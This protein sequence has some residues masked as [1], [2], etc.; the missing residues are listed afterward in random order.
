MKR[1]VKRWLTAVLRLAHGSAPK[2]HRIPFGVLRGR[3]IYMSP[4]MSLRMFFGKAE[5]GISQRLAKLLARDA[6]V[7][8][9]GAHLGYTVLL[10]DRELKG[11]GEIHA[12][13]LLPSTAAGLQKTID[14]N[15]MA[16]AVVHNVGV[17][18]KEQTLELPV[19]SM[20]M[21]NI[22]STGGEG[23]PVEPCRIVVLDDYAKEKQ[24]PPPAVM[25]IDV[26][27]A[28]L[29]CLQGGKDLIL[30][31]RPVMLIEFHNLGLLKEGH[32]LLHEWGYRLEAPTGEPVDEAYLR[33]LSRFHDTVYCFPK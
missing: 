4:D 14:A 31:N 30:G 23:Q 15:G 17:G 3:R 32:A 33:G 28:E 12:F 7:Y 10:I 16:N 1:I 19:G 26:E 29:D 25:K 22:F 6:V 21:G 2:V 8:D 24:L 11:S 20:G 5:G 18:R 27:T 9:I 13:E